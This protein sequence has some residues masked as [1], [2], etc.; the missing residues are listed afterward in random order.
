EAER[1]MVQRALPALEA[2]AE[3]LGSE[4]G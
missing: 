2:L 1:Q 4:R 3:Q